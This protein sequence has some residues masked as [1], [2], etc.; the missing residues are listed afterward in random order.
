MDAAVSLERLTPANVDAVH[1]Y[2]DLYPESPDGRRIVYSRFD[3][4]IPGPVRVV[5]ADRDGGPSRDVSAVVEGIGH[6]G[7]SPRWLSDTRISHYE[8][9]PSRGGHRSCIIDL[10]TGERETVEGALRMFSDVNQKAILQVSDRP[11]NAPGGDALDCLDLTT[12]RRFRL[13]ETEAAFGLHPD[14]VAGRIPRDQVSL[15][16]PKWSPDG[17]RLL[18]VFTNE[19][20]RRADDP[21]PRLK[22]IFTADADGSNLRFLGDFGDHPMWSPDGCYVYAHCRGADGKR[23]LVA[24]DVDGGRR[25]ILD[26]CPGIHSHLHPDGRRLA[27]DAMRRPQAGLS[28]LI[29]LDVQTG[30]RDVLATFEHPQT[31]HTAGYHIHPAWSRDGRR[32][33]FNASEG[34]RRGVYC[35]DF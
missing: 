8:A 18:A 10:A 6:V 7:A 35:I 31:D 12:G 29:L 11:E 4:P 19:N 13:L 24:F 17:R 30:K 34:G 2:Y 27:C 23:Q 25:V 1:A 32:L 9:P 20:R 26:D 15:T 16:N 33:Y 22:S 5:V 28:Q 21:T 3:G 14:T